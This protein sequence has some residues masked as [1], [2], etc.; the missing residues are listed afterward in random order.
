MHGIY[1]SIFELI[2]VFL[3]S[4]EA[5]KVENLVRFTQLY[6]EHGKRLM[7]QLGELSNLARF[8]PP[9]TRTFRRIVFGLLIFGFIAYV[10][11]I[12]GYQWLPAKWFFFAVLVL[13]APLILLL[14]LGAVYFCLA[15]IAALIEFVFEWVAKSTPAGT[16]GIIG[17][18]FYL[19]SWLMKLEF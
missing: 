17:F 11:N 12:V 10:S 14:S 1:A 9:L 8:V 15:I 13:L 2:G 4:I 18:V 6:R 19:A 5:I 7:N 16:T 3:L